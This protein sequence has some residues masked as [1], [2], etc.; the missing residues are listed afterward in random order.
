LIYRRFRN[1]STI[2]D[3]Q[4]TTIQRSKITQSTIA[5]DI[6]ACDAAGAGIARIGSQAVSVP[7]TIPGERVQIQTR[8]AR[9]GRV[10]A[11]LIEVVR[12]SPHRIA[13]RCPHFAPRVGPACG[14]CSW[15]HIAYVEQL[16]LKTELLT[17]LV[18]ASVPDAPQARPMLSGTPLDDPWRY[19]NKVHFVFGAV[20]DREGKMAMGHYAR[21]SRQVVSVGECPVHDDRGNAIAFALRD[22]CVKT[23]SGQTL[24]SVA[25][26]VGCRT[27]ET[28]ATLVVTNA[29]EKRLRAAT[30]AV[31]AGDAAPTSMHLNIHPK[32]DAFIFGRETRRLIGPA[33]LREDVAGVSFLIS[34][35]SFFQTNVRAAEMLVQLVLAAVP[36]G[37]TVLDL[38][39]GAGLFALPLARR[40]H[41]V[42]A[43][44]ENRDAVADGVASRDLNGIPEARCRF[45][46]AP[47][48][49]VVGAPAVSSRRRRPATP[50]ARLPPVDIVVL[51]PPRQGCERSVLHAV[52]GGMTPPHAV[53]VS[54]DPESLAVDL[55]LITQHG[56]AVRSIQPVDMF[57]HTPHIEAVVVVER[58]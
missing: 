28:T 9:D 1:K 38:Y 39:A 2:K 8:R 53:Y 25:V 21:G 50:P 36:Q 57:P 40:G 16:R 24:K 31:L 6:E 58:V 51:D 33:R 12:P 26:R 56:Y 48:E 44:E 54:C 22:A 32:D 47:V 37:A 13:P 45:I 10:T 55:R 29:N 5:V 20:D 4:S 7:L 46:A 17:R 49:R 15:Q 3:H 14:G 43:V 23:R 27:P 42:I 19:R 34:P 18:R 52:F 30:S 35:T 11:A 41:A